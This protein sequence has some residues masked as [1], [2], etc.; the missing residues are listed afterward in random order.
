MIIVSVHLRLARPSARN[1]QS[2]PFNDD[3]CHERRII[4]AEAKGA[5]PPKPEDFGY[6]SFPKQN[7]DDFRNP[8]TGMDKLWRKFGENPFIPLGNE[9]FWSEW[10]IIRFLHKLGVTYEGCQRVVMEIMTAEKFSYMFSL[11]M[12]MAWG[13]VGCKHMWMHYATECLDTHNMEIPSG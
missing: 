1:L 9:R 4:M 10:A 12:S 2:V 13:L 5:A 11:G 3:R 7:E 8:E 6:L